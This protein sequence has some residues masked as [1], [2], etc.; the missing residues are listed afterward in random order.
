MFSKLHA[1][2][3][4]I[5]SILTSRGCFYTVSSVT[6]LYVLKRLWKSSQQM[7]YN[8]KCTI[9]ITGCD[10][11][12][13]YSMAIHCKEKLNLNVIATCVTNVSTGALDLK[14]RGIFVLTL[15][16]GSDVSI[17]TCFNETC[18]VLRNNNLELKIFVNNAAVMTFGEFDWRPIE[19]IDNE[20]A[21]NLLGP[22]KLTK[23]FMDLIL[24]SKTRLINI[25]SH[26]SLETL[27][28]LVPYAMSKSA[29]LAWTN[30]LRT[31]LDK[32]QIKVIAV[33]PGTFYTQSSI[34]SDPHNF[35]TIMKE[36]MTQR[37]LS[38]QAMYSDYFHNYLDYVSF[39]SKY[40]VAFDTPV[41]IEDN[42]V[43]GNIHKALTD[44]NPRALYM[45]N[46]QFRYRFYHSLFRLLPI[47]YLKDRLIIYFMQM[48]KYHV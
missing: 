31:E 39:I 41:L 12:L 3:H 24:T 43:M 8:D 18:E 42:Q 45:C 20:I 15:E 30:G 1:I 33:I 25:C 37:P 34:M 21:I 38:V 23:L 48:P 35:N 28:G 16:L 11:G 29:L 14:S 19:S 27:P 9:F 32:Y 47:S 13:G 36:V 22:I 46:N 40:S 26:C 5:E 2:W 17:E 10:S 6:M 44:R 7:L 4:S